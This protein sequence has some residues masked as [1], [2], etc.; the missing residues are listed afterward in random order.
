MFE[1]KVIDLRPFFPYIMHYS[2]FHYVSVSS[3]T[4]GKVEYNILK[5]RNVLNVCAADYIE[6]V[7][8]IMN[9][10]KESSFIELIFFINI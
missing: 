7:D 4:Q 3:V 1:F 10:C 9:V 8:S 2:S 5:L 6:N